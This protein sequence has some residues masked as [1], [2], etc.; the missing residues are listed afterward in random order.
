MFIRLR[1]LRHFDVRSS[2]SHT[3]VQVDSACCHRVFMLAIK[4]CS[5]NE[6]RKQA[7]YVVGYSREAGQDILVLA[8]AKYDAIADKNSVD[9][10]FITFTSSVQ[11]ATTDPLHTST[12]L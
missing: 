2:N 1:V 9:I 12:Y 6:R 5:D 3:C 8:I 10:I 4:W 7:G 11:R